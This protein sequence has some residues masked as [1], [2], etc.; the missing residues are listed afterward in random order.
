[1]SGRRVGRGWQVGGALVALVVAVTMV[2]GC[3]GSNAKSSDSSA[4]GAANDVAK[5]AA[6]DAHASSAAA[7]SVPAGG[8]TGEA[9]SNGSSIISQI[10]LRSTA[11][12]ETAELTIATKNVANQADKAIQIAEQAGGGQSGEVQNVGNPGAAPATTTDLTLQVPPSA[13]QPVLTQLE[14]LGTERSLQLTS[15]DVTGQVADVNSRVSSAQASIA[16]LRTLFN[17]ATSVSDIIALEGDL[18]QREADLE[19]LQAQQRA[20]SAQTSF[21]TITMHLVTPTAVVPV[22]HHA[23]KGFGH[24]LARGWDGFT[25]ALVWGLTGFGAALPFLV[26]VL[27]IAGG[28]LWIR[29]RHHDQPG[30]VALA[31]SGPGII[32]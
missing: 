11:V 13:L 19:S 27:L 7:G 23:T 9:K 16:E 4:G 28:A 10:N 12:I 29:R 3:T 6:P 31:D 18:S 26:V 22:K 30:A 14:A 24:G 17:R 5:A 20:L 1:M 15:Q 25:A 32:E 2:A 21:A 8:A